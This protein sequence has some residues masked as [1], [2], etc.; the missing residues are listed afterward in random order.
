MQIIKDEKNTI[1]KNVQDFNIEQTLECGQ[2]FHYD[3]ISELEYVVVA[4]GRMLHVRQEGS[5]LIFY[6]VN[7]E[8]EL[9]MW[10]HYFDLN[11]D[12]SVIKSSLSDKGGMLKEAL[13]EKYGV[14]ILNQ[15]FYE[16]LLSFIISQSK[17][18]THIKQIIKSLSYKYGEFLGEMG[19]NQYYA[20][21]TIERLSKLSVSEFRECKTGYRAPY[22][23]DAVS[24]LSNGSLT[25]D[26]LR[27]LTIEKARE[28]LMSVKGVGVKVANCVLLYGLGYRE[29]FPV[30]VWI[31]RIMEELY[32]KREAHIEEIQALA[33]NKFGKHGGYAQQYLF[34]YG[35]EHKIGK[36]T[37]K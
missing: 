6:H 10:L 11:R 17:G 23:M 32:F 31:K 12:Y 3:K 35:R 13:A 20:F 5:E 25:D 15:E 8:E 21:P 29:A 34:Y 4:R 22:L 7:R 36:I 9:E 28:R 1:I 16:T 14:R 24:H 27:F 2:C 30:D 19:G 18:I 26:E 33:L 37:R